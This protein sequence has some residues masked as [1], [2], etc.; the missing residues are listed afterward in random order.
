MMLLVTVNVSGWVACEVSV[1]DDW[2][3][4]DEV[5]DAA[6]ESALESSSS[7]ED[8]SLEHADVQVDRPAGARG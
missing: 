8:F 4:G 7:W 2:K 1:D 6:I 5:P 3:P